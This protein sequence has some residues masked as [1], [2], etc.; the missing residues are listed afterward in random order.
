[1]SVYTPIGMEDA[2]AILRDY[3]IGAP[4]E[5]VGIAEGIENT[6]YFLTTAQG[7]YVLTIFE[8]IRREDLGYFLALME[9]LAARGIPCPRPVPRRDGT[10]L[11]SWQGKAGCIVTR[12]PGRTHARLSEAMLE[13]AGALLARMHLAARD[14][15]L[16]R[17]D[18]Q[19]LDW[20]RATGK[21]LADW[22]QARFGKAAAGLLAD[23]MR[24]Q[25]GFS[26]ANLPA[27]A[28]HGDLF[29]DNLLFEDG[30]LSGVID[31]YYAHDDA[32]AYDLAIAANA[33]AWAPEADACMRRVQALLAGYESVRRLEDAERDAWP[34]LL[35]RAALRFWI[36][37]LADMQAPREGEM[38]TI[39]DPEEFRT[40]LVFWRA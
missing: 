13:Q 28:V 33:L 37:R 35:R 4:E 26:T 29:A 7:R 5:L 1:M 36:S 19:G 40:R 18:T 27:G 25:E 6:N 21:R 16:H 39:K 9:H 31:L 23:E 10:P 2:R 15:P 30:H 24:A 17:K 22:V 34:M 20:M 14:F 8:R 3:A 38:T 11:F 12:L 32:W